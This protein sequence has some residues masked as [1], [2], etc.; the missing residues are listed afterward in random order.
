MTSPDR[1]RYASYPDSLGDYIFLAAPPNGDQEALFLSWLPDLYTRATILAADFEKQFHASAGDPPK[2]PVERT[3]FSSLPDIEEAA[4]IITA[5]DVEELDDIGGSGGSDP[6]QRVVESEQQEQCDGNGRLGNLTPDNSLA[7]VSG[8]LPADFERK[9][10][11]STPRQTLEDFSTDVKVRET[12]LPNAIDAMIDAMRENAIKNMLREAETVS[13]ASS[14]SNGDESPARAENAREISSCG[15]SDREKTSDVVAEHFSN[16]DPA[17]ACPMPEPSNSYST[18]PESQTMNE[19]TSLHVMAEPETVA[20][21]PE[22]PETSSGSPD[23]HHSSVEP[24]S[25]SPKIM[26]K[27]SAMAIDNLAVEHKAITCEPPAPP[28]E[29]LENKK[30]FLETSPARDKLPAGPADGLNATLPMENRQVPFEFDTKDV[31]ATSIENQRIL[32]MDAHGSRDSAKRV[33]AEDDQPSIKLDSEEVTAEPAERP[34]LVCS[35]GRGLRDSDVNPTAESGNEEMTATPTKLAPLFSSPGRGPRHSDVSIVAEGIQVPLESE[36]RD[37]ALAARAERP[38]VASLP[39]GLLPSAAVSTK[40]KPPTSIPASLLRTTPFSKWFGDTSLDD[41][42]STDS[43]LLASIE[44]QSFDLLADDP[45][46]SPQGHP[47][48]PSPASDDGFRALRSIVPPNENYSSQRSFTMDGEDCPTSE[49][50]FKPAAIAEAHNENQSA[51]SGNMYAD[52]RPRYSDGD[53]STA[54]LESL[55]EPPAKET[56]LSE[57]IPPSQSRIPAPA[58]PTSSPR[59]SFLPAPTA[60]STRLLRPRKERAKKLEE[61][62]REIQE[63][64]ASLMA[65]TETAHATEGASSSTATPSDTDGASLGTPA[66]LLTMPEEAIEALVERN[67]AINMVRRCA[68]KAMAVREMPAQSPTARLIQRMENRRRSNVPRVFTG[69]EG[70]SEDTGVANAGPGDEALGPIPPRKPSRLKWDEN[71]ISVIEFDRLQRTY[72]LSAAQEEDY[73][74]GNNQVT[75]KRD[76][77]PP[78]SSQT[79]QARLPIKSALRP[80]P[81]PYERVLSPELRAVEV[82]VWKLPPDPDEDGAAEQND[83][84]IADP[85]EFLNSG[86]QGFRA[87]RG[88]ARGRGTRGRRGGTGR[89]RK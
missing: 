74:E 49:A 31:P 4:G 69:G 76:V 15:A 42:T 89:G 27:T 12:P 1:P 29:T 46:F 62:L 17:V 65:L 35:P 13:Q 50:T 3:S 73:D 33:M 41:E 54:K 19:Q 83:I 24:V 18:A 82:P 5:A 64:K 37:V 16:T 79:T 14:R 8:P 87:V 75:S 2:A 44:D 10:P 52:V 85:I 67:H 53:T 39:T 60:S 71:L 68:I 66:D 26:Q 84:Q 88:S 45:D 25:P 23:C 55:A 6:L 40:A 20:T 43:A 70:S 81:V 59:R 11:T 9:L 72:L 22:R 61:T 47:L 32:L 77:T 38:L 48:V 28:H 57:N 51:C 34:L 7:L 80:T 63:K 56:R 58:L 36:I 78:A 30:L 21:S 86:L